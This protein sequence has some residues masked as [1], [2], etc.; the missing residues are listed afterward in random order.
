MECFVIFVMA[1]C[2][3]NAT[4]SKPQ[5]VVHNFIKTGMITDLDIFEESKYFENDGKKLKSDYLLYY[6]SKP[7][8]SEIP[9]NVKIFID[10]DYAFE[11]KL[12]WYK[13]PSQKR[14]VSSFKSNLLPDNIIEVLNEFNALENINLNELYCSK[15][16]E[17]AP[18]GISEDSYLLNFNSNTISINMT[19]YWTDEKLFVSKEEKLF[20]KLHKLL[21]L[22]KEKLY[23]D[24]TKLHE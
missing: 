8:W 14:L 3:F 7:Y 17:Y 19:S 1:W 20:L 2:W 16:E 4:E 22:W 9:R 24:I 23:N 18:E 12:F 15:E 10:K 11:V 6:Y 5:N 21:E 13:Y